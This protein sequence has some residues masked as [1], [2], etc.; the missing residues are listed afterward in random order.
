[1]VWEGDNAVVIGRNMIDAIRGDFSNDV[2]R[3]IC[4]G[5]YDVVSAIAEIDLWFTDQELC[6][7]AH[8]S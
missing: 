7:W 1:M 6:S 3:N 8:H 2:V 5:S 4:H